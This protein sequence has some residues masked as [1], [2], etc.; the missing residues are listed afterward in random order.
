[1]DLWEVVEEDYEVPPF[2]D[3]LS[4]NQTKIHRE[5]KTMKAKAR[6]CLFSIFSPFILTK[7]MQIESTTTIWEYLKNKYQWNERVQNMQVMNLI[8]EFEMSIM[9]E[10]QTIKD[11]AEQLLNIVNKMR[12]YGKEFSDERIVQKILVTLPEKYEATISSL[13]NSKNLSSISLAELVNVFQ[14][15]EQRSSSTLPSLKKNK[16]SSTKVLVEARSQVQQLW[17]IRPYGEGMENIARKRDQ[18]YNY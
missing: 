17:S 13:E 6:V 11:Y 9:K 4:I 18:G 2:G 14:A 3:N 10:S 5:R 1:M 15:L 16:S 12:L 8:R 7:I